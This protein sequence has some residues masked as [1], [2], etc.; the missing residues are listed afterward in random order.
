MKI[1]NR[2]YGLLLIVV[3]LSGCAALGTKTILKSSNLNAYQFTRIGYTQ[4]AD[5]ELLNEIR[6]NTSNI[7]D[8]TIKNFFNKNNIIAIGLFLPNFF[9]IEGIDKTEIVRMCQEQKLDG[10]ICTQVK[11]KFFNNYY[12]CIPLGKSEDAYVE[13]QLYDKNGLLLL[14]TKHNT[15]A[16]NSYMMPPKAEKTIRD[17]TE[18][19]LKQ[20]MK[21]IE[22]T[23]QQK[24][25]KYQPPINK[26]SFG[27]GTKQCSEAVL[28]RLS[29]KKLL[30]T[31]Y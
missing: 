29:G 20:I 3:I 10:I 31:N 2:I 16:G 4:I 1:C 11:Y 12:G 22:Q 13:M 27:R 17:G 24:L 5:E 6:P 8:S 28:G 9:S 15:Y 7:Y 26:A 19:T 25:N 23:Q 18:G 14:H 30:I 21:E